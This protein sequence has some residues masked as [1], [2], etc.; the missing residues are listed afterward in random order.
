MPIREGIKQMIM[1]MFDPVNHGDK[2]LLNAYSPKSPYTGKTVEQHLE[3]VRIQR[4]P[5]VGKK[6][7]GR[8]KSSSASKRADGCAV[9]GKTR[10]RMV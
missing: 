3:D 7:G 5:P 9:K 1:K 6:K 2:G 4:G 10:G 8:I